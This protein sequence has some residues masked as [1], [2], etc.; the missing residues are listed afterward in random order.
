MHIEAMTRT[1]V[2]HELAVHAHPTWY[3]KLLTWKTHQLK[4]LLMYYRTE[5]VD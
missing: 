3:H 2:I 5:Y 1:Q 4:A